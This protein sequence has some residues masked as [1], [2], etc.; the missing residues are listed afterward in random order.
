MTE[1]TI[2]KPV[3][4]CEH[5]GEGDFWGIDLDGTSWCMDCAQGM[6]SIDKDEWLRAA[7][8]PVPGSKGYYRAV[9]LRIKSLLS[10]H[11]HGDMQIEEEA[12]E[13]QEQIERIVYYIEDVLLGAE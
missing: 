5:C 9:L 1:K 12:E 7:H 2:L 8:E 3:D 11:I 10:P 13:L 6:V 4:F